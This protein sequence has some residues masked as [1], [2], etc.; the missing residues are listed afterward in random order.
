MQNWVR[1]RSYYL[2]LY[3]VHD[4]T[5]EVNYH[6]S[7]KMAAN[8]VVCGEFRAPRCPG[9]CRPVLPAQPHLR[10]RHRYR[11]TMKILLCVQQ[12]YEVRIWVSK[13]KETCYKP[14]SQDDEQARE[15]CYRLNCH[16]ERGNRKRIHTDFLK[17]RNCEMQEGQNYLDSVQEPHRWSHTS[18]SKIWEN[19]LQQSTKS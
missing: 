7:W 10:L 19:W 11:R 3:E 12:Q 14:Q 5:P 8:S 13:H 2:S 16:E 18:R 15:T 17:D 9:F 4:W 1:R 6:I